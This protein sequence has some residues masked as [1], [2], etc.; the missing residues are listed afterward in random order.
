V[1][2][3]TSGRA[4]I[5]W[6]DRSFGSG[7][8]SQSSLFAVGADAHSWGVDTFDRCICHGHNG[9]EIGSPR[10]A[11]GV[12]RASMAAVPAVGAAH[13]GGALVPERGAGAVSGGWSAGSV[14]GCYKV[15]FLLF[16]V[17]LYANHAHNL[18]R[19]P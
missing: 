9:G 8:S 1:E 4:T 11:G 10:R 3:I 16:T 12:Q 5:G 14:V 6:G 18:T 17:T 15:S 7:R 2:I 13:V 19:S